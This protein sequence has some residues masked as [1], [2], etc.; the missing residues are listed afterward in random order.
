MKHPI[1]TGSMLTVLGLGTCL[2]ALANDARAISLGGSVIANGEGAHGALANP[3]SMMVMKRRRESLHLS[4]SL[5]GEARDT[6]S[7]LNSVLDTGNQSLISDLERELDSIDSQQVQC[8]PLS[9][10]E[11]PCLTGTEG[12]SD[13]ARRLSDLLQAFDG[14]TI[15]AK[16]NGNIG[17]AITDKPFPFAVH[18]HGSLTT[19]GRPDL[20]DED[21]TY[22]QD[23]EQLLADGS[24][25][26]QDIAESEFLEIVPI[27]PDD[28]AAGFELAVTQAED[29]LSTEAQAS[30][31]LRT[32]LGLS[33]ATTVQVSSFEFDVGVTPKFS[34][35]KASRIQS[36]IR[37]EL[38]DTSALPSF[39]DRLKGSEVTENSFTFDIGASFEVPGQH[40]RVA[41]VLKN[42]VPES[43]STADGFEF[44]T[45]PQLIVGTYYQ[46]GKI[47]INGDI[48]LNA[49][50]VDGFETQILALGAEINN[51]GLA[52]RAGIS[53]D[54][55]RS[56][57][58]TG[59]TL[60]FGVGPMEISGK[61][62][63]SQSIKLGM[64]LAFTF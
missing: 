45:N 33:L 40:A 62:A 46:Y 2:P 9:L 17:L 25:S 36:N 7:A 8:S 22:I 14:E 47:G 61:L 1:L 39:A 43:I 12:L 38:G 60:G 56:S 63:G 48:A 49:A 44:E 16:I 58:G 55:S 32:Q 18:L 42:A 52:A 64:Q 30:L 23:F 57:G 34:T 29:V 53:H 41:A 3:A 37:D 21:I 35:L 10:P 26:L 5:D 6:G 15:D 27:N 28:P 54:I 20:G 31:L 24:I 4:F 59:L 19:A 13:I 11:D 51:R 50:K